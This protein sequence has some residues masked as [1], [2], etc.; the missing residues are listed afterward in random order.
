MSLPLTWGRTTRLNLRLIVAGLVMAALAVWATRRAWADAWAL[1]DVNGEN[2]HVFLAPL[3]VL[4][5]FWVRRGRLPHVRVTGRWAGSL[6][7]LAGWLLSMIGVERNVAAAFHLGSLVIVIGAFV[8]VCG[9]GAVLRFLP[10][11]FAL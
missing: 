2:S 10:A 9:K 6:L 7:I 8:S 5:L 3:V 4:W 11:A 1:A